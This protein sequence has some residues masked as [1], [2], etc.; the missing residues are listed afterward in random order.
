MGSIGEVT[1]PEPARSLDRA[2]SGTLATYK[3][4]NR[5]SAV[6]Q[7]QWSKRPDGSWWL[8]ANVA[9]EQLAGDGVFVIWRNGGGVKVSAVL[10]VG[11]GSLRN[12][13]ARCHRDPLFSSEGLYVTWATVHDMRMLD[14]IGSYLYHQLHPLWGE[15]V[16]TPP[17]PVNLPLTA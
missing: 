8:F 14:P 16:I 13:F 6:L 10:Y 15:A 1:P 3:S 11:R 9:P 17:I 5:E 2:D 7:L 4:W 12:E